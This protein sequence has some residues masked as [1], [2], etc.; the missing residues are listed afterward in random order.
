MNSIRSETRET[1]AG[2]RE[3]MRENNRAFVY[4]VGSLEPIGEGVY[5]LRM[6]YDKSVWHIEPYE[7]QELCVYLEKKE[8]IRLGPVITT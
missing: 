2:R 8:G 1:A 3:A 7:S 5:Q 6:P 4:F